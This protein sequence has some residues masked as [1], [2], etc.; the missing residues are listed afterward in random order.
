MTKVFLEYDKARDDYKIVV[1]VENE[2]LVLDGD[3]VRVPAKFKVAYNDPTEP[4]VDDDWYGAT[5]LSGEQIDINLFYGAV[6]PTSITASVY[7]VDEEG[8]IDTAHPLLALDKIAYVEK[9]FYTGWFGAEWFV[10][11]E[12]PY[13]SEGEIYDGGYTLYEK[14]RSNPS[15]CIDGTPLERVGSSY[16]VED[17]IT[18]FIFREVD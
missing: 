4:K 6:E 11:K 18:R 9:K 2:M 1:F 17:L 16:T 5:L 13:S 14:S 8:H 3:D 10:V 15:L 12:Q 7:P